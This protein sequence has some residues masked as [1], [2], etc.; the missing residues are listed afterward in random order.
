MRSF[1]RFD[2]VSPIAAITVFLSVKGPAD[3]QGQLAFDDGLFHIAV[4]AD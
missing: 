4:G 2:T 1:R 3:S